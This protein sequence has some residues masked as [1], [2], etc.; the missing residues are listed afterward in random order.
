MHPRGRKTWQLRTPIGGKS[1]VLTLGYW[2]EMSVRSARRLARNRREMAARGEDPRKGENPVSLT[3]QAFA[4]RWI[5]EVVSKSRKNPAPIERRL[6]RDILPRMGMLKLGQ[7]TVDDVRRLIFAKRDG[8]RPAAAVALRD[9][10]FRMFE[11]ARVH[12]LVKLNPA[13]PLERKFIARLRSRKRALSESE[14]RKLYLNGRFSGG[15]LGI[16]NWIAL[17]LLL[18]TLARKSELLEARWKHI[19]LEKGLWE[20]PAELSKSGL[21]HVVYLSRQAEDLFRE[22]VPVA[23]EQ[24]DSKHSHPGTRRVDPDEY[25]FQHQSSRTQPMSPNCLNRAISRVPWGMPHFTP[26]D[27]RRTASTIL[28]EKGYVPDVIEKALNHAVRGGVRGIYNRAQYAAERKQMLQEWADYL[29]G[30]K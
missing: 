20:V 26:H 5:R 16:R 6:T 24:P 23:A 4:K 30:L 21:P 11:Y 15:R 12:G 17:E 7:I 29:E 19:D 25:V 14:L 28:N 27:L 22:L 2:P 13:E 18:L 10:L 9:L 1:V 8:G 3:V